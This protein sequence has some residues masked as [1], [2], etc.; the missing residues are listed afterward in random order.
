MFTEKNLPMLIV[1]TPIVAVLFFALLVIYFFINTQYVNFHKESAELE[2]EYLL[3]QKSILKSENQRV[4]EY[5]EFHRKLENRR[6]HN[7]F[8]E[9]EKNGTE[10]TS[11]IFSE[12]EERALKNL[13]SRVIDWVHTIRYG[14][15]GYIWIH[16][17]NHRLVAHPFRGYDIG[18]DDT[19]NTDFTGAKIFQQF[20]DI[21]KENVDGGFVEYYWVKPKLEAPRKKIGFLQLD[22]RW[23]WVVGTGLYV[24]D[25]KSSVIKKKLV[26]ENKIDSYIQTTLLMALSLMVIL[27][28]VSYFISRHTVEIFTEYREKVSK[29][30]QAL[31][32]FNKQ[33]TSRV[34]KAL[35][36]A[37]AKD[38][39]LLQ[40]S[41]LAQMGEMISMIAHQWRQPLC[42]ISGIFM[43]MESAVKFN[44]A[45]KEFI[46]EGSTEGSRIISYM[47]KT[48]D[49]FRDFFKPAKRKELFSIKRACEEA[50]TLSE[51]SLKSRN[52]ILSLHVN[53][54][55]N[56]EGYSSEFAQV[57]LNLILNAKDALKSRDI[58]N[59]H[60]TIEISKDSK[61]STIKVSDNAKGIELDIIL[62]VFEPY[63]S[64]KKR[65]G[66]G[67][68]LYMSKMI[69]ED[70]MGG[71]LS[72][73]NSDGG[74]VFCI[75][76]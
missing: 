47:S 29:K 32:E 62:R 41:R 55:S 40:Q 11:K 71:K 54:D 51:A 52:I 33:L 8:R 68:G 57:I 69:I 75:E 36:E 1:L 13:K 5:I 59:P 4:L 35:K 70:N 31:K 27:G 16:N 53:S 44:K 15:N 18:S 63:F 38:Q 72:V 28:L 6:I 64:T 42:E 24:D 65:S 30:E 22:E 2:R 20:V 45:D 49:D 39:A 19:N 23:G 17:T 43:E 48:I 73:E 76:I 12:Y 7:R 60:I 46:K 26:L 66:A 61:N 74:A 56:I 3:K 34:D 14:E 37:K 50:I 10:V 21:A 67:L 58:D 25:I 9:L